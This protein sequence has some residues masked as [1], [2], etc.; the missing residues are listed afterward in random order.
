M[1]IDRG[2]IATLIDE[3]GST[4][5]DSTSEKKTHHPTNSVYLKIVVQKLMNDRRCRLKFEFFGLE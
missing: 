3:M 5:P 4:P 1:I 2:I